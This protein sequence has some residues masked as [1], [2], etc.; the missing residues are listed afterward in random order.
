MGRR[1]FIQRRSR[2]FD[3]NPLKHNFEK[4]GSITSIWINIVDLADSTWEECSYIL[5]ISQLPVVSVRCALGAPKGRRPAFA[6]WR[7]ASTSKARLS[8][9]VRKRSSAHDV[10]YTMP[11]DFQ[12]EDSTH[13]LSGTI[14]KLQADG[15]G[16]PNSL[17]RWRRSAFLGRFG[18]REPMVSR[19]NFD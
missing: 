1:P 7:I 2:R 8:P 15:R 5:R 19:R 14:I 12:P 3:E 9:K 18:L 11:I 16:G 13:R 10:S 17:F 6:F 4:L